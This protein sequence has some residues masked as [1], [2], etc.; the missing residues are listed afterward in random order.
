MVSRYSKMGR[1]RLYLLLKNLK[2]NNYS[3]NWAWQVCTKNVVNNIFQCLFKKS[4]VRSSTDRLWLVGTRPSNKTRVIGILPFC[5]T[6]LSPKKVPRIRRQCVVVLWCQRFE[7]FTPPPPTQG[8]KQ[9]AKWSVIARRTVD[10]L[11]FFQWPSKTSLMELEINVAFVKCSAATLSA[12]A[13]N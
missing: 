13:S 9:E 7:M 4:K 10:V 1:S 12:P 2:Q 6:A 3:V 8:V 5:T 11:L